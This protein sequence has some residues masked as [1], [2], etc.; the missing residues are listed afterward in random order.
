MKLRGQRSGDQK[1]RVR[2]GRVYRKEKEAGQRGEA[3]AGRPIADAPLLRTHKNSRQAAACLSEPLSQA[4]RRAGGEGPRARQAAPA[5][6]R[7]VTV[8]PVPERYL[9]TGAGLDRR[10]CPPV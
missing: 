5:A 9:C 3:P 1:F 10:R 4:K 8:C 7:K 2:T 6:I